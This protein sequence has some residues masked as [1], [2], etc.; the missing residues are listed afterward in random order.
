MKENSRIIMNSIC[1]QLEPTKDYFNIMYGVRR[2]SV[3]DGNNFIKTVLMIFL[4]LQK[5]ERD[6]SFQIDLGEM[7]GGATPGKILKCIVTIV[8]DEGKFICR[9]AFIDAHIFVLSRLVKVF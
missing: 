2:I 5:S 9:F 8:N 3:N 6:E 4:I 1:S 7:D